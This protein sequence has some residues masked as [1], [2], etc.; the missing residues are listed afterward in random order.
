MSFGLDPELF[1]VKRG[2]RL[3]TSIHKL[4]NFK[5][6]KT[7]D[8]GNPI[9]I[10][11]RTDG[12]A[13]EFNSDPTTCRDYL[14]P[15]T[16]FAIRQFHIDYPDWKLDA[17][18]SL[19]L[20]KLSV[21]G[22]TPEGV[23]NYGC[24]PDRDAFTLEEKTPERESYHDEF[25]YTGGH[26]HQGIRGF[27][28]FTT[29]TGLQRAATAKSLELFN[30]ELQEKLA[31][32]I[33]LLLDRMIG[34]PMVAIIGKTNDTGEALRRTYYGQA[35][36][37]RV[38]PYGV[39]YRVL[40]GALLASPFQMGWAFG[41]MR[42]VLNCFFAKYPTHRSVIG[43]SGYYEPSK[44]DITVEQLDEIVG[45]WFDE[46]EL[47]EVKR[48]IDNHDVD[49]AR[50]YW[51]TINRTS[52]SYLPSFVDLMIRADKKEIG[53]PRNLTTAW[54]IGPRKPAPRNHQSPG[55]EKLMNGWSDRY[56]VP[57]LQFPMV[58]DIKKQTG[59]MK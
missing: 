44:I 29:G 22:R 57:A 38:K 4:P 23:C 34:L 24:V 47:R 36:S 32:A 50:E 25:R 8:P 27:P 28:K 41:Q 42:H 46:Y 26:M 7:M 15:G 56:P 40:S 5:P 58:K 20:N 54:N 30:P 43:S 52:V 6:R 19:K 1:V 13:F 53:L 49:A 18:A 45:G 37:H 12:W 35:G 33:T 11:S 3:A 59:W 17:A 48:I 21:K 14:I 39:E 10:T 55:V 31:A 16:G 51:K 2:S 9:G